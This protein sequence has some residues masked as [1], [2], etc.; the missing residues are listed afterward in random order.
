MGVDAVLEPYLEDNPRILELDD[1]QLRRLSLMVGQ[2]DET[3]GIDHLVA[4]LADNTSMAGDGVIRCYVGFEPSGKA[5]IGW[6]VLS[7]QLRRMLDADANVLIFLADWHAWVNDKYNGNMDDIQTT[8]TYMEET[9]RAL[10]GH[11]EEGEGPGE[12]RF[13]WASEIMNSGDY[14]ARVLRCSKGATL[15][16]VRKT[17]TI[18]GRDEASSDHDLSKFFYPAMQASDI[19]EMNIDVALGGM[20]QRKA[21]MFMR[22]V[23]SRWNWKKP[24]CLHTPIL[25]SLKATGVRM[26]SFDHKMSKSDPSGAILLHD[27]AK[28]LRKKMQKHAY[29]D[30]VDPHSP[31]Y[32]L[33]EHVV[34]PEWGEIIVTPNPKF[35]EP[36]TWTDLASFKAA[37]ADGT[38]HPLD[39]KLGVADGVSK[40]LQ[41]VHE[42]FEK[43]PDTLEAVTSIRRK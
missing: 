13:V 34:I 40:G 10:L 20:D 21:H 42:H 8:A 12:L 37:V 29:L 35:G 4:C 33:A 43:N 39:A 22:D 1:E 26:E 30:P 38:L 32:E 17:F 7:L 25:S 28:A 5:H 14:W 41:S 11:P 18:M 15:P 24:T 23:A 6:K 19:F 36:S 16:K 9:F 27:A 31:V 2:V 3:V